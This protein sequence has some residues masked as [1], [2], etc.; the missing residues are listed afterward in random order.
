MEDG[1]KMR[2]YYSYSG[3]SIIKMPGE[4]VVT[5]HWLC[6]HASRNAVYNK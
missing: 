6:R 1:I 2:Q 4:M 5:N 3:I